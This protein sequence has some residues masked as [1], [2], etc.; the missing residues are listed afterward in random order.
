MKIH[1]SFK[2]WLER[3]DEPPPLGDPAR[4][5]DLIR[6]GEGGCEHL[7]M[8]VRSM[9]TPTTSAF[10]TWKKKKLRRH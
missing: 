1:S 3:L 6:G 8:G 2:K 7:P 9:C 5:P 4:R 10:P